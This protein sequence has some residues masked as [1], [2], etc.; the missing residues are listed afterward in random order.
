MKCSH[1]AKQDQCPVAKLMPVHTQGLELIAKMI[2]ADDLLL[3]GMILS[4]QCRL[5]HCMSP[6]GT[7]MRR[8]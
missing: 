5:D 4:W 1:T 7:P 6:D 3:L 8:L 2:V